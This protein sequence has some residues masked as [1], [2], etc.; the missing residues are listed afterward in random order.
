MRSLRVDTGIGVGTEVSWNYASDKGYGRVVRVHKENVTR[1]I[2]GSQI[3]RNGTSENPALEIMVEGGGMALKLTSEVSRSDAEGITIAGDILS[4]K[5]FDAIASVDDEDVSEAIASYL[6]ENNLSVPLVQG[7]FAT[8]DLDTATLSFAVGANGAL[9]FTDDLIGKFVSYEIPYT[10]A[11]GG[12]ALTESLFNRFKPTFVVIQNDL[13]IV[14]FEYPEA[15]VD[16]SDG[17]I[18]LVL[19]LVLW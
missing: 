8:L 12:V 10:I 11:T 16:Q 4:E 18:N 17:E 2:K 14:S 7:T 9:K 6:D 3:T 13:K 19:A 1:T 5:D 15:I